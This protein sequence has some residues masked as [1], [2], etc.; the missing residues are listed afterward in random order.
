M[1]PKPNAVP[2][3]VPTGERDVV[4]VPD[5]GIWEGPNALLATTREYF[6]SP[7]HRQCMQAQKY[8]WSPVADIAW[9]RP[10]TIK[11]NLQELGWQ[12][13]SQASYAEQAGLLTA[14]S[15]VACFDDPGARL[16]LAF[17]TADEARH[18]E[19]F[20]RYAVIRGGSLEPTESHLEAMYDG[21]ISLE[22]PLE[23]LIVHVLLEGFAVEQLSLL[24]EG[25]S[26]DVLG[27]IYRLVRRDE[28]RH[29]AFGM[30]LI[31]QEIC[32]RY[33]ELDLFQ[34]Q[35]ER[36]G[37]KTI[38][39]AGVNEGTYEWLSQLTSTPVDEVRSNLLGR[40]KQRIAQMCRSH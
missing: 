19:V 12:L 38:Q 7:L 32:T 10:V 20:A 5:D 37:T 15:L 34:Q 23:R 27:S 16:N 9:D 29:V 33:G 30:S 14:A 36:L 21:I 39:L 25:F 11:P 2:A 31:R 3:W 4:R 8:S 1:N 26:E 6:T 35:A 24:A 18:A 13:A 22:D 40:H 28:A 17:A